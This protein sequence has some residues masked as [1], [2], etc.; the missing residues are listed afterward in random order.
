MKY[1]FFI[2]AL[3][4]ALTVVGTSA[5]SRN[6]RNSGLPKNYTY[7]KDGVLYHDALEGE[8]WYE[9]ALNCR[10][11]ASKL[12]EING[13]GEYDVIK[14]TPGQ[15]IIIDKNPYIP[16]RDLSKRPEV[17]EGDY[18]YN[19]TRYNHD[20]AYYNKVNAE[21]QA[22]NYTP[23]DEDDYAPAGNSYRGD[24]DS[25]G[26]DIRNVPERKKQDNSYNQSVPPRQGYQ[27]QYNDSEQ[28]ANI[29]D[30]KQQR[31]EEQLRKREE[32]ARKKRQQREMNEARKRQDEMDASTRYEQDQ[33]AKQKKEEE[34]AAKK[35]KE[36]EKAAKKKKDEEL[37]A[38]KK[39][40]EELAAKKKK[41]EELAAKKK[42][43]EEQA[44]KKQQTAKAGTYE[45]KE[46]NNLSTIAAKH[47]V[48]VEEL[49]KANPGLK[50]DKLSIGQK[51]NIPKKSKTTQSKQQ[52]GTTTAAGKKGGYE[53]QQ[54]NTLT[55]I[56]AKHGVTVEELRKANP[57]LKGDKLSI[58]QKLNIPKKKK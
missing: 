11:E 9:I 44:A 37:A 1:R 41:E 39:K 51:L 32:E 12:A 14:P 49:R 3:V 48:T 47:G 56:A 18:G 21:H 26:R 52:A 28:G 22:G 7:I 34:K 24:T 27:Q 36:E 31:Q 45:V 4:V 54:G 5:Q 53:V 20:F 16:K 40:E 25:R 33:A 42:K 58:G 38:K 8:S 19:E 13:Y 30:K 35:K 55:S 46:G 15:R 50:G 43:E 10:V 2:T 23:G 29:T 17:K 57:S 6:N